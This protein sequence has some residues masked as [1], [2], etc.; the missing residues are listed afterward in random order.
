MEYVKQMT[1]RDLAL[2][3]DNNDLVQQQYLAHPPMRQSYEKLM[4]C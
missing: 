3:Y 1:D 4:V 2:Y